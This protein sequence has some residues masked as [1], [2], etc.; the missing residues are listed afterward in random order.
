MPKKFLFMFLIAGLLLFSIG[1]SPVMKRSYIDQDATIVGAGSMIN[2]AFEQINLV[3][4]LDP[5]YKGL[6]FLGKN[7]DVIAKYQDDSITGKEIDVAFRAFML[8]DNF[9]ETIEQRR[10]AVQEYILAASQ[11]RCNYFKNLLQTYRA[12]TNFALGSL[13]T[14][15]GGLGAILTNASAA[16]SLAGTAAILNGVD[17]EFDQQFFS[18]LAT[19]VIVPGIDKRRSELYEEMVKYGQSKRYNVYNVEA[20]VKDAIYYHGQCNVITGI[21]E[22]GDAIKVLEDPGVDAFNRILKRFKETQNLLNNSVNYRND[23]KLYFVKPL[24]VNKDAIG[25]LRAGTPR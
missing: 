9:N 8:Y 17:A 11:N 24:G 13:T 22:A 21:N 12:G 18:N 4:L 1:C 16:R 19:R 2:P 25:I 15:A 3:S 5:A 20:A 14:I 10:N 23:K 7:Q 6:K